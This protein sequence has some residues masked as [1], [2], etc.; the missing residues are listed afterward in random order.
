MWVL[1]E[2]YLDYQSSRHTRRPGFEQSGPERLGD[3]SR[4]RGNTPVATLDFGLMQKS[5]N[6]QRPPDCRA[7]A[8]GWENMLEPGAF[9]GRHRRAAEQKSFHASG[10]LPESPPRT[11]RPKQAAR[12]QHLG[13]VED[14]AKVA[15]PRRERGQTEKTDRREEKRG[16]MT[17]R[18]WERERE[19][20]EEGGATGRCFSRANRT[21]AALCASA[22]RVKWSQGSGSV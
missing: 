12:L 17:E 22:E 19:A 10:S 9:T 7:A 15:T 21:K 8:A 4:L 13:K 1:A 3:L 2:V 20:G 6:K 16:R 5:V 11:P 18:A 14:E